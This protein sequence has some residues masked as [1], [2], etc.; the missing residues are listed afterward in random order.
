[1]RRRRR[2][3]VAVRRSHQAYRWRSFADTAGKWLKAS[4]FLA[5]A[6]V[7]AGGVHRL[8]TESPRLSVTRVSFEGS[9]PAD[10][11]RDPPVAVGDRL[12]LSTR[13]LRDRIRDRYP[14]LARIDVRRGWDRSVTVRLTTRT[15]TA[16]R[17]DGGIWRGI[18]ADGR[19]F[20]LEG[21]GEGLVTLVPASPA[22]SPAPALTFLGLLRATDEPWTRGLY[23]IK[24]SSDGEA[25]LFAASD[26]PV[27]W[28]PLVLD[29]A[30]VGAKARRLGRVLN[31]PEARQG[32]VYARFVDD[33]R[34]VVKPSPPKEKEKDAK[35]GHRHGT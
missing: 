11:L 30:L 12:F 13:R 7:V 31:A 6:V 34:I 27:H 33:R 10:L 29:P 17:F 25:T 21:D 18:D 23:K 20:P 26:L 3:K 2:L 22:D 1:M 32:L 24:M 8:W 4:L 15:P 5:S 14:Q 9:V 35:A 19:S 16:K 28:G